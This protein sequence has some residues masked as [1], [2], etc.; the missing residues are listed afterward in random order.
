M[1]AL[2]ELL[3]SQLHQRLRINLF[4]ITALSPSDP[5]VLSVDAACESSHS[6]TNRKLFIGSHHGAKVEQGLGISLY[7]SHTNGGHAVV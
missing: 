3:T 7:I 1:V 2:N 4:V 5:L 6:R